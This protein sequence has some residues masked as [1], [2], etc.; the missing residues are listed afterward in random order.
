MDIPCTKGQGNW[1]EEILGPRLLG[2]NSTS[3]RLRWSDW[4]RTVC[5]FASGNHIAQPVVLRPPRGRESGPVFLLAA[6]SAGVR[7]F[8]EETLI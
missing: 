6:S 3:N 4:K 5:N 7:I 8:A 2:A 1:K